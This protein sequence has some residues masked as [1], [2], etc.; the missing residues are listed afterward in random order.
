[1]KSSLEVILSMKQHHTN[2]AEFAGT[3][4]RSEWASD[5]FPVI[6]FQWCQHV[7]QRITSVEW[8]LKATATAKTTT[9]FQLGL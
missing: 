9:L 4:C 1:M 2:P 3:E 6:I 5:V 7:S 8:H